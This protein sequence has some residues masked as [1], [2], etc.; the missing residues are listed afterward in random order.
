M[1][2]FTL[3]LFVLSSLINAGF[4]QRL[5]PAQKVNIYDLKAQELIHDYKITNP[6]NRLIYPF[7]LI[8]SPEKSLKS[9]ATIKL[10]SVIVSTR[11]N[12]SD[13]WIQINKQIFVYDNEYRLNK[14][15]SSAGVTIFWP[16]NIEYIYNETG[17]IDSVKLYYIG[18]QMKDMSLY[19]YIKL[20]YDGSEK[21]LKAY[22]YILNDNTW[23]LLMG[24]NYSYNQSGKVS[25]IFLEE[26]WWSYWTSLHKFTYDQEGKLV[27]YEESPFYD[28]VATYDYDS[29]GNLIE[30]NYQDW[31]QRK[32]K[33]FFYN[34]EGN[35]TKSEIY[36]WSKDWQN[37]D[38][39][40]IFRDHSMEEYTYMNLNNDDLVNLNLSVL[41]LTNELDELEYHPKNVLL[42]ILK[43]DEK[44]EYFYSPI[45]KERITAVENLNEVAINIFP[46]PASSQ[47]IFTWKT[48]NIQLNLKVF[49]LTGAC[50][51]DKY[52]QSNE[53]VQLNKL[54]SGV[55]LY[56]LA[57]K[58]NI[59]QSGKLVIR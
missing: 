22:S 52:I 56:K 34:E 26:N 20:S 58:E 51:I 42:T 10:D 17:L 39:D 33:L 59:L 1:K 41:N 12:T 50:M 14:I 8:N 9:A 46:N 19:G 48:S 28:I 11:T 55:Y 16:E 43:K 2:K 25:E 54:T 35:R 24:Y 5:N 47:V 31:Y 27:R 30:E 40:F 49:G 7:A 15:L 21:L 44:H 3:L 36:C 37:L 45:I 4:A 13:Q 32:E 23:E 57:D 6:L 29:D 53:P 38:N 18:D